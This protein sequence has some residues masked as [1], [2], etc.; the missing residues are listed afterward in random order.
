MLFRVSKPSFWFNTQR[1]RSVVLKPS[2]LNWAIEPTPDNSTPAFQTL[3]EVSPSRSIPPSKNRVT[4]APC[5]AATADWGYL[6][7]GN[8]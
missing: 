7:W 2:R 8:V 4:I 1:Y 5:V 6:V 3:R